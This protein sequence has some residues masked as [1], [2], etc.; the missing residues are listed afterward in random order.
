MHLFRDI[1]EHL[2][3]DFSLQICVW[4]VGSQA[5]HREEHESDGD[6][7][8]TKCFHP[9]NLYF[10]RTPFEERQREDWKVGKEKGKKTV[11]REE[12]RKRWEKETKEKQRT[13]ERKKGRKRVQGLIL[14]SALA[15]ALSCPVLFFFFWFF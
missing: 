3:D 9:F 13:V 14:A 5:E 10:K 4:N 7:R 6:F 8:Q 12:E 15:V 11:E 1:I 2:K